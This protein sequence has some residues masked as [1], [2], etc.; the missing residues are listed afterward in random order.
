MANKLENFGLEGF[1]EEEESLMGLIGYVIEKGSAVASY[2]GT[3]YFFKAAGDVD[4]YLGTNLREDGN[5]Q[6]SDFITHGSN[7]CVWNVKHTGIELTPP[8]TAGLVRSAIFCGDGEKDGI[9]PIEV[10]T[11]DVLPSF[12]EGEKY[13][14]QVTALPVDIN[15][16]ADE[17]DYSD[18][19]PTADDGNK[20]LLSVGTLA[21]LH[22][23]YN[24]SK[25]TY[26]KGKEYESDILVSFAAKVKNV[27]Y[28]E[29][30]S[31]G[32]EYKTFIRCLVDTEFGE[33]EFAHTL[34]QVPQENR[35]NI[36]V[37]SIISGLCIISG[38]VAIYD[39]KDGIVKNFDNNLRLLR[40][41]MAGGDPLRLKSVLA[42]NAV[43]ETDTGGMKYDGP[44][45]IIDKFIYIHENREE[46]Y[47]TY[48]ATI[49]K[50]DIDN[51]EYP[52]GTRCIVLAAGDAED[53]Y[54]SIAFIDVNDDGMITRIKVSRD[55]KYHFR[56]EQP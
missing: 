54:E 14:I 30:N 36:K 10:I 43:Y 44:Q 15:Y 55:C 39:Y 20:W 6:M 9:I 32:E 8:K 12:M 31:F 50:T 51:M 4:F 2:Y 28:G 1:V 3:P 27:F 37:G 22:F 13:S 7:R 17:D 25:S 19:Q 23:L 34:E 52:V 33:L 29:F 47:T 41:T 42:D 11:A 49:V 21:P 56:I 5:L 45:K 53:D 40:Y 18:S 46:K 26:E 35:K 16:F 38:D 48:Y 24:H